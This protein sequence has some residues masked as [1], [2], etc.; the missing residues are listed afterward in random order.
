MWRFPLRRRRC[1]VAKMLVEEW[2]VQVVAPRGASADELRAV[3]T[4]LD[5][6]VRLWHREVSAELSS[7]RPGWTLTIV[8]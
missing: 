4:L 1:E 6:S 8:P 7:S 3:R 5:V 2:I